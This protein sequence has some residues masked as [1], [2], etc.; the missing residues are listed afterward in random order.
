MKRSSIADN[1]VFPEPLSPTTA[2]VRPGM[3]SRSTAVTAS[4]AAECVSGQR[5]PARR[6]EIGQRFARSNRRGL[7]GSVTGA[8]LSINS[9]TRSPLCR[10]RL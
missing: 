1:V 6:N 2:T 5:A 10:D 3:S 9:M 7:T 8:G 4:G